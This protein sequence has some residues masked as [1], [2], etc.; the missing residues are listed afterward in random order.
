MPIHVKTAIK[1]YFKVV[2]E[3]E[4]NKVCILELFKMSLK[5]GFMELFTCWIRC[6]MTLKWWYNLPFYL[7]EN[8]ILWSCDLHIRFLVF[9]LL[10]WG[11]LW[12]VLKQATYQPNSK[13]EMHFKAMNVPKIEKSYSWWWN[14]YLPC[15]DM[16]VGT[17]SGLSSVGNG[18]GTRWIDAR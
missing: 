4:K 5:N 2:L 11:W 16:R 7:P 1:E 6:D 13:L 14:I 9:V 3:E 18:T 8:S 12:H 15:Y 10:E 17:S